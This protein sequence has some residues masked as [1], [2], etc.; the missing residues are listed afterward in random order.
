MK[1]H[2]LNAL[3]QTSKENRLLF[4]KP[5]EKPATAAEGAK[6]EGK[7]ADKPA[8]AAEGAKTDKPE[9]P[10]EADFKAKSQEKIT[11]LKTI[12]GPVS[13]NKDGKY[14]KGL[15]ET[16]K[17]TIAAITEIEE[18][19]KDEKA[20]EKKVNKEKAKKALLKLEEAL[21]VF[22]KEELEANEKAQKDLIALRK[23]LEDKKKEI[24][25]DEV[26]KK[27]GVKP[28][29]LEA[30]KKEYGLKDKYDALFKKE[31]DSIKDDPSISTKDLQAKIHKLNE[32]LDELTVD[33]VIEGI[34]TIEKLKKFNEKAYEVMKK[35]NDGKDLD[36][37][38]EEFKG[39]MGTYKLGEHE[40]SEEKAKAKSIMDALK[41]NQEALKKEGIVLG[42]LGGTDGNDFKKELDSNPEFNKN[43][44]EAFTGL[45]AFDVNGKVSP[46][47][48]ADQKDLIGKYLA[49][50]DVKAFFSDAAIKSKFFD[51]GGLF[52]LALSY[53]RAQDRKRTFTG[54]KDA[55]LDPKE[56]VLVI[57]RGTSKDQKNEE[58]KSG[59]VLIEAKVGDIS[60]Y[61][62]FRTEIKKNSP[63][64]TDEEIEAKTMEVFKEGKYGGSFEGALVNPEFQK[65]VNERLNKAPEAPAYTMEFKD[66]KL[67]V[68]FK[69]EEKPREYIVGKLPDGVTAKVEDG[70]YLVI[71]SGEDKAFIELDSSKVASQDFVK[72]SMSLRRSHAITIDVKAN[73]PTITVEKRKEVADHG[74]IYNEETKELTVKNKDTGKVDKYKINAPADVE[75]SAT[76]SDDGDFFLNITAG[77]KNAWIEFDE[78]GKFVAD[79]S[80]EAKAKGLELAKTHDTTLD[81]TNINIKAKVAPEVAAKKTF[82]EAKASG[83]I[84]ENKTEAGKW[85]PKA[86]YI[87]VDSP[88]GKATAV[89]QNWAV[90]PAP[91]AAPV[92][93]LSE[94]EKE[95]KNYY[96]GKGIPHMTE[97]EALAEGHIKVGANDKIETKEGYTWV[98][99]GED[100][101]GKYEGHSNYAVKKV[102]APA[103]V[104]PVEPPTPIKPPAPEVTPPA[105]PNAAEEQ[106]RA[107]KAAAA[108]ALKT[109]LG[110]A[111]TSVEAKIKDVE[112]TID[113]EEGA[114]TKGAAKDKM[115]A[116]KSDL[117]ITFAN[118]KGLLGEAEAFAKAGKTSEAK[119]KYDEAQK[120]LDAKLVEAQEADSRE[121]YL[122]QGTRDKIKELRDEVAAQQTKVKASF[123]KV[124]K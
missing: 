123:D 100:E 60:Q 30:K 87:W 34:K 44:K 91:E 36:F 21:K 18:I 7:D 58:R 74:Y 69:D 117:N 4:E 15:A 73:P 39:V 101:K 45:L 48:T 115:A 13:E 9:N 88:V 120:V 10:T 112:T 105:A 122:A 19:L 118:V 124:T 86:G 89:E 108:E 53:Q 40:N 119:N 25:E 62:E 37:T 22:S 71:T 1:T 14:T 76:E 16:A 93:E 78:S 49:A 114:L 67:T 50:T 56:D 51:G 42:F 38:L 12:V 110:A 28:E 107:E 55:V 32:E 17:K 99:S 52:D 85:Q 46:V 29:E 90:K 41:K 59:I 57:E 26:L 31:E 92:K 6:A 72:D 116:A 8:P 23:K 11:T 24:T 102:E 84:E 106:A 5:G 65:A 94:K 81:G 43:K 82:E 97:A 121:S 54:K 2:F 27:L 20:L 113:A 33:S 79:S 47:L 95:D 66:N 103:P 111:K 80:D 3:L 75:I 61:R 83:D 70:K 96:K 68:K 109:T 35:G 98:V 77:D 104:P 64:A 63:N